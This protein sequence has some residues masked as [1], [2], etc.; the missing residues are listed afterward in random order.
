VGV[1]EHEAAGQ[2]VLCLG[3]GPLSDGTVFRENGALLVEGGRILKVGRFDELAGE[4]AETIDVR[5]RLILPGFLN[6]HHHLYS[7]FA[8]GIRPKGEPRNFREILEMLWW[9]LDE[10]LD[11]DAIRWSAM[12]GLLESVRSGVTAI[13]DH[14][15]SMSSPRGSLA[16]LKDAFLEVGVRG[17]LCYEISDR[18]GKKEARLHLEENLSLH[19]D[20]ERRQA[21]SAAAHGATAADVIPG[22]G[23]S[24]GG[25]AAAGVT[26]VGEPP[27]L[28]A[29]LGLHANF[30]LSA[31]TLKA[32]GAARPA[33]MPVHVHCGEAAD[34]L[35][36]CRAEGFAG[37][38]DRLDAFGLVDADSLLV[39]CVHLSARDFEVVRSRGAVAVVNPESNANNRVGLPDFASLPRLL[40]GTDGMTGDVVSSWRSAFLL[41]AERGLSIEALDGAAFAEARRVR[42]RFFPGTGAF[43]PGMAADAAVLDYAPLS[44]VSRGNLLGHLLFG[45]KKGNAWLTMAGGEVLYREGRFLKVD[46][47]E[48]LREARRAA[49]RLHARYYGRS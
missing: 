27:F 48:I 43:E 13:F 46:E 37:P 1:R 11:E 18:R 16:V 17:L 12:A 9:P 32:A 7:S 8:P 20:L 29:A 25:E 49:K 3:G 36:F 14:H 31:E 40:V 24:A 19:E 38:A 4:A 15:A 42:E 33:G 39:H 26:E 28:K 45:A 30:T 35:E 10:A 21:A 41:G 47:D 2:A 22:A 5:G 23:P 44:P 34:D 6:P